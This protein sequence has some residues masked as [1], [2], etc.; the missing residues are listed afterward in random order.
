MPHL[1]VSLP[2]LPTQPP[3]LISVLPTLNEKV[4]VALKV[5]IVFADL[6]DEPM[7][8]LLS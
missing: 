7:Q 6:V 4:D 3:I 1:N 8:F 2:Q 5:A